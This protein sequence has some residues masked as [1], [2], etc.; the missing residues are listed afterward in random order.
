MASV[1]ERPQSKA[2]PAAKERVSPT[3]PES[4]TK[5]ATESKPVSTASR[6]LWME[7]FSSSQHNQMERDDYIVAAS[8]FGI[9]TVIFM[10]GL[11]LTAMAVLLS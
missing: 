6:P 11:I 7:R 8:I 1:V 9:L 10:I 4:P 3:K 5:A 2:V